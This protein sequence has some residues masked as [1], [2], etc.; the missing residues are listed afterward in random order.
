MD[1]EELVDIFNAMDSNGLLRQSHLLT[2]QSKFAWG[3]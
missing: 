3:F 1:K 2:G